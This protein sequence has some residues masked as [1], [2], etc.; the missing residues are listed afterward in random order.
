[1]GIFH[2]FRRFATSATTRSQTQGGRAAMPPN[3]GRC[4]FLSN[5]YSNV[6]HNWAISGSWRPGPHFG[7]ARRNAEA[8]KALKQLGANILVVCMRSL[9]AS[10][11]H[12]LVLHMTHGRQHVTKQK[13]TRNAALF[14][15]LRAH[16]Y[17]GRR[18]P[19]VS[20]SCSSL[21]GN[22]MQRPATL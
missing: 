5:C 9:G 1:M 8:T 12:R 18:S 11:L 2:V 10:T 16:V 20:T 21:A 14:F 19:A 4:D 17:F 6:I 15:K 13:T 3:A 22:S 7:K